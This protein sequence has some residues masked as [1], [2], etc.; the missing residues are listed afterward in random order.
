VLTVQRE[1][2][3]EAARP[4]AHRLALPVAVGAGLAGAAGFVALVDP[5]EP[6]HYPVCPTYALSGIW[7]PGCGM[8]R[9]THALLHGDV[10]GAL[11]FNPLAPLVIGAIVLAWVLW[12]WGRWSG[13][14]L[15]WT[16]SRLTPWM[17]A[18]GFVAFT[19]ARN[20]PGWTWLSPS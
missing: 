6:G 18:A 13:T 20:I 17:L 15:R 10:A 2:V 5:S 19:I 7:C 3:H 9:A 1:A 4:R 16:P 11:G 12:A 8:L 14:T